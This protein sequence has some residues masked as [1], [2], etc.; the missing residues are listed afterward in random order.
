MSQ[1]ILPGFQPT[2]EPPR[3]PK[4]LSLSTDRSKPLKKFGGLKDRLFLGIG[5]DAQAAY[6]ARQAAWNLRTRH[7]LKSWPRRK[8]LMHVSL[9]HIGD[10]N[11]FPGGLVEKVTEAAA[12]VRTRP[13]EVEFDQV[14]SFRHC[15]VLVGDEGVVGV[16]RLEN[17]I[18][19]ALERGQIRE[20]S[21]HFS[22]HVT[23]MY[24]QTVIPTERLRQPVRWKVEEFV[25]IHSLLGESRHAVLQTFPLDGGCR[26]F[27]QWQRP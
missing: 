21:R 24:D 6:S 7:H 8:S 18:G 16:R 13:F 5:L 17:E 12:S 9:R 15:I 19:E 27:T 3:K 4:D 26:K 20:P 2:P 14:T 25:L 1:F 10:F 11:G 22:P 23:L